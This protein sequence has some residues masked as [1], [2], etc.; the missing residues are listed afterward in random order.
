MDRLDQLW[1]IGEGYKQSL[2]INVVMWHPAPEGTGLADCEILVRSGGT[3]LATGSGANP[4]EAFSLL[5]ERLRE[6]RMTGQI[7]GSAG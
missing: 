4:D 2:Q 7:T 6:L 5:V 3:T 1:E